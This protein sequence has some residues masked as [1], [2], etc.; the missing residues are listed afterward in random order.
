MRV[1]Q[2]RAG[3]KRWCRLM[4]LA[5]CGLVT[6]GCRSD[7][8]LVA[9]LLD[10]IGDTRDA[11]G[12]ADRGC[13]TENCPPP[14]CTG[15]MAT[16]RIV[17]SNVGL[18]VAIDE[19]QVTIEIAQPHSY[20]L[21][22][23]DSGEVR[24]FADA[25]LD[26]DSSVVV[27]AAGQGAG[28]EN[29]IGFRLLNQGEEN[30]AIG[31]FTL[32]SLDVTLGATLAGRGAHPLVILVAD[33]ISILGTVDVSSFRESGRR[34]IGAGG[35]QQGAPRGPGGGEGGG[36]PGESEDRATAGGGGGGFASPGGTG[37][38]GATRD[39][40]GGA[41]GPRY[42]NELLVPL[43]GG[44]GGAGGGGLSNGGAGGG[45]I[46]L[47]SAQQISV[48]GTI[49]ACGGGGN[50]SADFVGGG[51]GGGSGGAILLE[52]PQ[53][54]VTGFLGANGA[55]GVGSNSDAVNGRP[56]VAPAPGT[57]SGAGAGSNARGAAGHAPED[58]S[59][60]GGGGGGGAG[61]IRIN[62]ADGVAHDADGSVLP[63]TASGF[64]TWGQLRYSQTPQ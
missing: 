61:W 13:L 17:P 53:V 26:I 38:A 52:A 16:C 9:G 39:L 19:S 20:W 33:E 43:S 60:P 15:D 4:A 5:T 41:G 11:S 57:P 58:A 28:S 55:S 59:R 14:G 27:R 54:T 62:S 25:S 49:S 40:L 29:Q 51:G 24:A 3:P 18:R 45:A 35:R 37:T 12:P 48:S 63:S 10:S 2:M 34:T 50:A 21:F 46:Q 23:T 42:G 6:G 7:Q 31:V 44:S 30:Q 8:L 1:V 47:S 56:E 32:G 36:R 22:D 64:Y